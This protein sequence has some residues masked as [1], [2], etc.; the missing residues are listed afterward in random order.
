MDCKN[1]GP[2]VSERLKIDLGVRDHQM[3]VEYKVGALSNRLDDEWTKCQV[4]HEVSVHH[5]QVDI[6]DPR[7]LDFS[8]LCFEV[9]EIS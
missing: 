8:D 4:R 6:L 1:V 9:P 7:I 5:I 3:D 2:T